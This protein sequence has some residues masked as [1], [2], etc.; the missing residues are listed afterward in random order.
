VD[1]TVIK[2]LDELRK[3]LEDGVISFGTYWNECQ[4]IISNYKASQP[5][6]GWLNDNHVRK[7]TRG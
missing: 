5:Y 7:Q 1:E 2:M 4:N 6:L 3:K